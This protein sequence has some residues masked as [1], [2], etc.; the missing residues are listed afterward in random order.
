MG[1]ERSVGSGTEERMEG[2]SATRRAPRV[3]W[4]PTDLLGWIA[5]PRRHWGLILACALAGVLAMLAAAVLLIGPRYAITA[6]IMVNLGPEMVGSPLLAAR[7]GTPAAPAMRRPE[8]SATGV[9]IFSNPRLIRETVAQLGEDFFRGPPPATFFQ[10]TKHAVVSAMRDV[11]G[12]IGEVLIAAGLRPRLSELDRLTLAI[13]S[14]LRVEPVRRTDVISV[15]LTSSDPHSGEILLGRF[16]ELAVAG[17][18]QAYRLPGAT[19]FF[20]AGRLERRAELRAAEERLLALRMAGRTAV[21]S[22]GE[23]R[24]VLIRAEAELQQQLRQLNATIAAVETEVRQGEATLAGLPGEIELSAI[25]SRNATADELRSR[26]TELRLDLITQQARYGDDS[27]EIGDI[28]RQAEALAAL[29]GAEDAFRID[30]VTMGVNQ[31]RQSLERDIVARRIDLEG[32]RSRRRILEAEVE[33]LRDELRR[34]EAAAIEIA[35]LDQDVARMRRAVDIY[36]RG[37]EDARVSE[38][39]QAVQLSGLRVVMP[40]TAELMPSSPSLRRLVLLGLVAGLALAAGL[41]LLREYRA[42]GRVHD[43]GGGADKPP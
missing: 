32:Q 3:T 13:G 2:D 37:F 38:A 31:L 28:R 7:E 33:T 40:P 19:E 35:T 21:W 43:G 1:V 23:Q 41:V 9:E 29:L 26:L 34:I 4:V 27:R 18:V 24:T 16:I 10:R 25:R 42:G 12:A 39:M 22:A 11:Q 30:Q 36:E 6:K 5:L 8:D 14:A 15:V 17:H 20:A